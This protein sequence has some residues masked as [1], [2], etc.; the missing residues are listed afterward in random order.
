MTDQ[1]YRIT[2]DEAVS[3]A[4]VR[5]VAS[6]EDVDPLDLDV[7]LFDVLDPDA[8]DRLFRNDSA[9]GQAAFTYHG[10]EVT[11]HADGRLELADR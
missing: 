5:A 2:E 1:Q 6:V 8:L 9:V 10:Y 3:D 7:R 11:V 4:V